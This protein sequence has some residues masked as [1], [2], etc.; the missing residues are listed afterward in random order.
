MVARSFYCKGVLGWVGGGCWAGGG[1]WLNEGGSL[2][3]GEFGVQGGGF[4]ELVEGRGGGN[5]TRGSFVR[6]GFVRGKQQVVKCSKRQVWCHWA[7]GG[8]GVGRSGRVVDLAW[9]GVGVWGR[10]VDLACVV[11]WARI[12]LPVP[13]PSIADAQPPLTRQWLGRPSPGGIVSSEL[14]ALWMVSMVSM[15]SMVSMLYSQLV[16][17]WEVW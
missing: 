14:I 13:C 16:S 1:L 11:D 4:K 2:D 15:E 5:P 10:V 9:G 6:V 3:S 7:C 8:L 12:G 17:S